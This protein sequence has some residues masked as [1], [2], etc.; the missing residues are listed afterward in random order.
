MSAN[1]VDDDDDDDASATL[2]E[3]GVLDN[4]AIYHCK[5]AV[6]IQNFVLRRK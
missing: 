1:N 6:V 5:S 2:I 3:D 4:S